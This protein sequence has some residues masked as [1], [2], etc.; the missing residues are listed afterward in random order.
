[1]GYLSSYSESVKLGEKTVV[2]FHQTVDDD[3]EC[4]DH[5]HCAILLRGLFDPLKFGNAFFF[6]VVAEANLR[7]KP[8]LVYNGRHGLYEQ[9][10]V[11]GLVLQRALECFNVLHESL[12]L[13]LANFDGLVDGSL[14][15]R[16]VVHC[17]P[18]QLG[19]VRL[20]CLN[21]TFKHNELR[22]RGRAG[23]LEVATKTVD[24]SAEICY[25][26]P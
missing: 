22:V 7:L 9:L 23:S 24:L 25:E 4:D 19:N 5:L 3:A 6:W 10:V 17:L 11:A 14:G 18:G 21:T 15:R 16:S 26:S 1:M 8:Q 13:E 12:H 20:E 2:G